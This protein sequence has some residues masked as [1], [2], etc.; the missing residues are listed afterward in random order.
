[1]L[2]RSPA[3][4]GSLSQ[5]ALAQRRLRRSAA[6]RL[7]CSTNGCA[8]FLELDGSGRA[9]VCPI[10]GAHRLLSASDRAAFAAAN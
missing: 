5:R 2:S 3:T 7:L 6:R 10:C 4:P 8:T 1:M 9:A